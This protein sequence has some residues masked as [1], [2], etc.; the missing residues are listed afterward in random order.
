MSEIFSSVLS[1]AELLHKLRHLGYDLVIRCCIQILTIY[2]IIIYIPFIA[3]F[4]ASLLPFKVEL[5]TLLIEIP[6]CVGRLLLAPVAFALAYTI[7]YVWEGETKFMISGD[8]IKEII[9]KIMKSGS[10]SYEKLLKY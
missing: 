2:I 3:S 4:I 10:L 6:P 9:E 7:W 5:P 1:V 8:F